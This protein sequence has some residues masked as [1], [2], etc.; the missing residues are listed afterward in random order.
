MK[1]RADLGLGGNPPR[2]LRYAAFTPNVARRASILSQRID[3]FQ[4][5]VAW[6]APAPGAFISKAAGRRA[7]KRLE[8]VYTLTLRRQAPGTRLHVDFVWRRA[9]APLSVR[10]RLYVRC[11]ES[12]NALFILLSH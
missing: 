3:A 1:G 6:N 11:D 8:R 12:D 2:S 10:T 5:P 9:A 7:S 4:A